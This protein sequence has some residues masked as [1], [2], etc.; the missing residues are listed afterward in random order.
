MAGALPELKPLLL[1]WQQAMTAM[2]LRLLRAFALS[3]SLPEQA[4]DSLYGDKP[5]EHIKL[6]R[7]PGRE[8][9][10]SGQ[11]LAPIKTPVFSASCCRTG[12]KV[13]RLKWMKGAGLTPNRL[14]IPLW[15]T[16]ANCWSWQPTA[17]CAPRYI[18]WRRRRRGAST[19]DCFLP[20]GATGRGGACVSAA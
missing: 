19:V 16:L 11:G 17:T 6:I 12:R 13:C 14:R 3:L 1:Q 20:R 15:S 5:N 9:T 10:A 2:S 8:A 7:Y 18:G 4:F